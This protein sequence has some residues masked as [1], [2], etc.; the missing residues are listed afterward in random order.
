MATMPDMN[1]KLNVATE[2]V[3]AVVIRP[4]DTLVIALAGH[5][6][7]AAADRAR[8]WAMARLPGLADVVVV[9]ANQLAVYRPDEMRLADDAPR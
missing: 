5:V 7:R 4:G 9:A 8:Q 6:D 2:F 3:D 1:L